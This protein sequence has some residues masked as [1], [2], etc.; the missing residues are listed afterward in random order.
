MH[1]V[2]GS[3]EN[4]VVRYNLALLKVKLAQDSST[5]TPQTLTALQRYIHTPIINTIHRMYCDFILLLVGVCLDP[6]LEN[7]TFRN[8]IN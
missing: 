8:F 2:S 4:V 6:C 3:C 1:A 5:L 7:Y